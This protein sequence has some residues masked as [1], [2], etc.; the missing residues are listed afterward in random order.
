EPRARKPRSK[1][2]DER[3]ASNC[4]EAEHSA[5]ISRATSGP[6]KGSGLRLRASLAEDFAPK[7]ARRDVKQATFR[8]IISI[9]SLDAMTDNAQRAKLVTNGEALVARHLPEGAFAEFNR[10]L[11]IDPCN[12]AALRGRASISLNAGENVE[13][14]SDLGRAIE[15]DPTDP[16]SW[17]AR[18]D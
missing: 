9:S 5:Y 14:I 11:A 8:L 18:A 3:P 15:I 7:S 16:A 6:R 2:G 17:K 13:A 4:P 1:P 12:V 10:A